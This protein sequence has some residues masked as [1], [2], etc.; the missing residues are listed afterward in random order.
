MVS[1]LS[2]ALSRIGPWTIEDVDGTSRSIKSAE[3][4]LALFELFSLRQCP[5]TVGEISRQLGMPQPSVTMLVRNLLKLGYLEHDR[6]ARTYVPTVRIMLLGSWLHRRM[7]KQGDLETHLDRLLEQVGETVT[8]G[9]QNGIYSQY[10]S[11]QLPE[12]P[13]RMEIQSGLLRPITCTAVGRVLLSFKP[14]SEVEMIARRCNA[15]V[16]PEHRI[17]TGELLEIIAQVRQDGYAET[18]GVMTEGYGAIATGVDAPIG[19][20][21]IAVAVGGRI[22]RIQS[23]R[24]T[25]LA[26]FREFKQ[27]MEGQSGSA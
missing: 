21:P 13:T 16:D 2:E 9:I 3:R 15:E 22:E 6:E 4:T 5:L 20:I 10:V 11:V 7:S 12:D 27:R 18:S 23:K 17:K 14:D 24:E 8:L 25:I 26:A 19:K 1:I